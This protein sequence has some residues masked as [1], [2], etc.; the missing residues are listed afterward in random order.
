M[1]ILQFK[2]ANDTMG[3]SSSTKGVRKHLKRF[4]SPQ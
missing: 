1:Q 4:L 2:C 3:Y